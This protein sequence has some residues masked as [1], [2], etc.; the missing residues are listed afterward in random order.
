M[1]TAF[2]IKDKKQFVFVR[3]I[4]GQAFPDLRLSE[5]ICGKK[6]GRLIPQSPVPN[7]GWV[8]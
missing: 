1:K 4:R 6:G 5:K 7:T 8:S 3:E 2:A